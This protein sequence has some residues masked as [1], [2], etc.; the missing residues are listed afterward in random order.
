M[1]RFLSNMSESNFHQNDATDNKS[2]KKAGNNINE[3]GSP[4]GSLNKLDNKAPK[5]ST[6]FLNI[7]RPKSGQTGNESVQYNSKK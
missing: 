1:R 3:L 4:K 2:I 5:G 7:G 6:N